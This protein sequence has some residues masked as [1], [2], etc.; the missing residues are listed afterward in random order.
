LW[1]GKH[2][3]GGYEILRSKVKDAFLKMKD[4]R[5]QDKILDAIR[6]GEW[7]IQELLALNRLHKYRTLRKRYDS[8]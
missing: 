6:K 5:D 2:Y 3:P 4:E 1:A 7:V 8:K